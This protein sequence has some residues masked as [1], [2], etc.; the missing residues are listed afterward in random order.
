MLANL[1]MVNLLTAASAATFCTSSIATLSRRL[2]ENRPNQNVLFRAGAIMLDEVIG[3]TG[4]QTYRI[5][6]VL[7]VQDFASNWYVVVEFSPCGY[8]IYCLGSGDFTELAPFAPSP[9]ASCGDFSNLIYVPELGYFEKTSDSVIDL[10]SKIRIASSNLPSFQKLSE[11]IY[12][13]LVADIIEDNVRFVADSRNLPASEINQLRSS[14]LRSSGPIEEDNFRPSDVIVQA[15]VEVP[16]SWFFKYNEY[17]FPANP[18]DSCGPTAL[19]IVL[20]YHDIF[21]SAGYFSRQEYQEYF[22]LSTGAYGKSVPTHSDSFL[23]VWDG[24]TSTVVGDMEDL[25]NDFLKDKS[26]RYSCSTKTWIAGNVTDA[27]DRGNPAIYFGNMEFYTGKKGHALVVY[28]YFDDGKL[29]CH[30]GHDFYT[31]TIMEPLGIF[32]L[33]GYF[34]LR[35]ESPHAHRG[36]WVRSDGLKICGCGLV[37][38]C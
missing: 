17:Q 16:F 3:Y 21:S 24:V 23:E 2:S 13:S 37:G 18:G 25:T 20:A 5:S 15:D 34:E 9:Y 31:Q 35:N 8:G 11:K 10:S 6:R 28:G 36:Y 26:V 22:E 38:V 14:P 30:T 33:G 19:S 4:D 27:I 7:P 32:E 1:L 29:L 12:H